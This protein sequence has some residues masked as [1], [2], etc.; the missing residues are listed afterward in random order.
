MRR[1]RLPLIIN[2]IDTNPKLEPQSR[3]ALQD[4][5][6]KSVMFL[7]LLDIEGEM[8]GSVGLDI[9]HE[10]FNFDPETANTAN[11]IVSQVAVGLQN[12][13]LLRN[14]QRYARQMQRIAAFNQTV[15][16][17]LKMPSIF[18]NVAETTRDLLDPDYMSVMM[19]DE[20]REQLRMVVQDD[21]QISIDVVSGA[22]VPMEDT[23]SGRAW[24]TR[25]VLYIPDMQAE[26]DLH[27]PFR[28]DLRTVLTVPI[29]A[30]GDLKGVV[31]VSS[32]QPNLF[33]D[34][35]IVVF[36][37]MTNQL[38]VAVENAEAYTQSQRLAE[39]KT[40]ANEISA[41]IQQQMDIDSILNVTMT[42]LGRALGARHARIRLGQQ[43]T[44]GDD[45]QKTE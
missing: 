15:E 20:N 7:P 38:G 26:P 6:V 42:E 11:A 8:I 43:E 19:Y 24:N 40:L 36:Q 12:I 23:V 32:R 44:D 10:E 1:E 30:R 2:D 27:H 16:A 37:Q 25:D 35:D 9:F 13:R 14:A 33:S 28:E 5:N 31:E 45:G 4:L 18:Q 17:T 41:Q 39:N 21:G 34:T 29:L 3:A 22:L